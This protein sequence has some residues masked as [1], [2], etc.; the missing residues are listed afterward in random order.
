V[1]EVRGVFAPEE[2]ARVRQRVLELARADAR[3][4]CGALTGSA[5]VGTEDRWSD[6]DL[7]FG[8]VDVADPEAVLGD[9]T[10]L[11]EGELDV[12]SGG[13]SVAQRRLRMSSTSPR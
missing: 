3:I 1:V 4:S 7:S 9:L 10:K 6:I 2:R 5:V 11:L 12:L 13:C 8:V